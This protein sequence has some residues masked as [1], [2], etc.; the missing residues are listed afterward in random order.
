MDPNTLNLDPDPGYWLNLDPDPGP[1][2]HPD[3]G[4]KNQY[5]TKKKK[6]IEKNKFLLKKFN[7][8]KL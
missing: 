4:L 1:D 7:F 3:P 5:C 8:F 2:L 6:I